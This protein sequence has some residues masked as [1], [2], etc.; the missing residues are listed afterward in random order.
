[1]PLFI[2][3]NSHS[4]RLLFL[5]ELRDKKTRELYQQVREAEAAAIKDKFEKRQKLLKR[6]GHD[7]SRM[8]IARDANMQN[9]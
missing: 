2:Y 5:Q 6:N 4:C 1:M 8:E 9:K 3:S 7:T